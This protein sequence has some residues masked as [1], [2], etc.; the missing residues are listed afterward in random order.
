MSNRKIK[1]K[2]TKKSC[3][4]LPHVASRCGPLL[5]PPDVGCLALSAVAQIT[6]NEHVV[7]QRLWPRR[8]FF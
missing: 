1:K 7:L 4:P 5:W 2:R 3:L 6:F 8:G